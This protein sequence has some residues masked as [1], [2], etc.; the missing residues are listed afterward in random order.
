MKVYQI[1]ATVVVED[2]LSESKIKVV[3]NENIEKAIEKAIMEDFCIGNCFANY[4]LKE[5]INYPDL[6][7]LDIE[8]LHDE[9]YG[10]KYDEWMKKS[11]EVIDRYL[12]EMRNP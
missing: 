5:T 11:Q 8:K 6:P 7:P 10:D 4:E 9:V 12:I 2:N 3:C 1:L